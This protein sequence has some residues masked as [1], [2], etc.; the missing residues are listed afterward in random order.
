MDTSESQTK[1]SEMQPLPIKPG[2]QEN[3]PLQTRS[4][5]FHQSGPS[6]EQILAIAK[7]TI[8]RI[9]EK[10]LY[11]LNEQSLENSELNKDHIFKALGGLHECDLHLANLNL[12][13]VPVEIIDVIRDMIFR[14]TFAHNRL[15]DISNLSTGFLQCYNLKYLVLRDNQFKEFPEAVRKM[16]S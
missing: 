16:H 6:R 11:K 13:Q 8:T 7:A 10:I 15:R 2:H 3:S 14:L 4:E 9:D 12:T 1:S 5:P